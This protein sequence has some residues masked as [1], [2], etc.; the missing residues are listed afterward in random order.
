MQ[1]GRSPS[2]KSQHRLSPSLLSRSL[3]Q[4]RLSAKRNCRLLLGPVV[5]QAFILT[6]LGEWGDRSQV[7]TIALAAAHVSVAS[8]NSP[9]FVHSVLLT[10]VAT[11]AIR[12]RTCSHSSRV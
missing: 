3:S 10:G 6:F 11:S 7:A 1:K 9:A 8:N 12:L 5:A 4:A 2:P